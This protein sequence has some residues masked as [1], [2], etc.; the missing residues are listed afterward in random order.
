MNEDTYLITF[1]GG[2]RGFQRIFFAPCASY[3]AE[4]LRTLV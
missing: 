2:D 3:L 4:G 1:F